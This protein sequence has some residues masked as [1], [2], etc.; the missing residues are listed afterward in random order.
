MLQPFRIHQFVTIMSVFPG[1][2]K[3]L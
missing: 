1:I 3:T 2:Q